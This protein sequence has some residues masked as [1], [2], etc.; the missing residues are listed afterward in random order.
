M[1]CGGHTVYNSVWPPF[2]G[3]LQ[4]QGSVQSSKLTGY[5]NHL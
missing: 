1:V 4:K 3:R 5:T 2:R